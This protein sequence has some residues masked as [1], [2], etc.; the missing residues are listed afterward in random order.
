MVTKI[1][2]FLFYIQSHFRRRVAFRAIAV[3]CLSVF[4]VLS[5]TTKMRANTLPGA[6]TVKEEEK[7]RGDGY[8]NPVEE[9][10]RDNNSKPTQNVATVDK[11]ISSRS[12]SEALV[13]GRKTL[14]ESSTIDQ[15]MMLLEKHQ[16]RRINDHVVIVSAGLEHQKQLFELGTSNDLFQLFF[17]AKPFRKY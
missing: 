2:L 9:K 12:Y 13:I 17:K 1:E 3:G 15:E 10:R 5:T 8:E 14:L 11:I 4:S 16:R 7:N 6:T